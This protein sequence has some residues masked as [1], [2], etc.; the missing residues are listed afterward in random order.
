MRTKTV[1]KL[2]RSLTPDE[3]SR[4]RSLNLRWGGYMQ[5]EL[6][7]ARKGQRGSAKAVMIVESDT[8]R[9]IAWSLLLPKD[10][11]TIAHYYTRR[12]CRRQGYGDRLM[13]KVQTLAPKP[14]V[15]PGED[16]MSQRFFGKHKEN[17]TITNVYSL[18][19]S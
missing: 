7:F 8:D 19:E 15:V 1:V 10:E 18:Y 13:K 17:L 16:I 4:C 14:I 2:V 5:E 3:Y 9:L 12:S 11:Q 6:G